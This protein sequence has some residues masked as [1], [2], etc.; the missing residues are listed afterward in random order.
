MLKALKERYCLLKMYNDDGWG[1]H[2]ELVEKL[3]V[4]IAELAEEYPEIKE[5]A[6]E[7]ECRCQDLEIARIKLLEAI[8]KETTK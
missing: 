1:Q 5:L 8:E 7:L 2:W 6:K 4:N 3:A